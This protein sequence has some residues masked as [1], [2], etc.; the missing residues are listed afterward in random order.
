MTITDDIIITKA[1]KIGTVE[2]IPNDPTELNRKKST[3]QSK[4]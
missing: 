3:M 2:E 1:D 4:N